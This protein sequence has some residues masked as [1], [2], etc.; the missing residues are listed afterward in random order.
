[1]NEDNNKKIKDS[2]IKL[3]LKLKLPLKSKEKKNSE[4]EEKSE[5]L[6][7]QSILTLIE[8]I[9]SIY[10]ISLSM[11]TDEEVKNYINSTNLK[12]LNNF[13]YY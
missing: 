8:Y 2:L 1:M 10:D 11:K 6:S 5:N 9:S 3:Y 4:N 13:N 12:Y 7:N